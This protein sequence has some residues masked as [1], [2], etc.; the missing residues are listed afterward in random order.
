MNSTNG[1][2]MFSEII[3]NNQYLRQL[4]GLDFSAWAMNTTH[5]HQMFSDIGNKNQ[6]RCLRMYF[7]I[8]RVKT[9]P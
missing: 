2:K 6:N 9:S 4:S 8:S 5:W 7:F 1:P 3:N